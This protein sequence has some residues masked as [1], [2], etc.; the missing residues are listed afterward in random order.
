[1]KNIGT[2][3]WEEYGTKYF[4]WLCK[5][6]AI[7]KPEDWYY[8]SQENICDLKGNSFLRWHKGMLNML[9]FYYPGMKLTDIS[10]T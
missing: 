7:N 5:V 9:K 6:L 1:M 2:K 4:E 3:F 10:T 8:I